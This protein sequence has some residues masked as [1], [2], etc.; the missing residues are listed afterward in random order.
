MP[1]E[2]HVRVSGLPVVPAPLTAFA[3]SR[4]W[5]FFQTWFTVPSPPTS[6][7]RTSATCATCG[8]VTAPGRGSSASRKLVSAPLY[9]G[10]DMVCSAP[11]SPCSPREKMGIVHKSVC[12]TAAGCV[13]GQLSSPVTTSRCPST[14]LASRLTACSRCCA[15][16][17][18]RC[19]RPAATTHRLLCG[20]WSW[21]SP[22]LFA[23]RGFRW[24]GCVPTEP[25]R[26]SAHSLPV[27]SGSF[28]VMNYAS[29]LG[30][31]ETRT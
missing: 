23:G 2:R 20:L 30:N 24:S 15:L 11:F 18:C 26:V 1:R 4:S 3:M 25:T 16:C 12:S 8:S 28:C 10:R 7:A 5:L 13:W 31:D 9:R 22:C 17:R 6:S 29:R 27:V 19:R 21:T 14:L